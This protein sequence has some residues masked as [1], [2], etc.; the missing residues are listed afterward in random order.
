[1]KNYFT[2]ILSFLTIY[3]FGQ[4][5]VVSIIPHYPESGKEIKIT[6]EGA[7][8]KEDSKVSCILYYS[9]LYNVLEKVIPTQ[10]IDNKLIG[11]FTL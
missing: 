11:T 9:N 2:T 10:Y 7:L 3:G 1:M 5:N 4:H 6:Y 8:A